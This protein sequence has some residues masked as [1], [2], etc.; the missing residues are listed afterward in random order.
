MLETVRK[1]EREVESDRG[2]KGRDI[3][4]EERKYRGERG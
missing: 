1:I 4:G 2:R 3:G